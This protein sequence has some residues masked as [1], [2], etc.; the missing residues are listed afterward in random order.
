MATQERKRPWYLALALSVAL[1][2]GM[3]GAFGGY[4]SVMLYRAPNAI[5]ALPAAATHDIA[6][7]ADRAAVQLRFD[8]YVAALDASRARGWPLAVAT[9]LLGGAIVVFAT[10]TIAGSRS[11]R[12]ALLQLVFAQ[13]GLTV[14]SAWLM[15]DVDDAA[16]RFNNAYQS[17]VDHENA[18]ERRGADRTLFHVPS[19]W[20]P[21]VLALRT[22]SSAFVLVALTRRRARHFFDAASPA[23]EE[24]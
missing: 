8:A 18:R 6:D 11:G 5:L 3:M 21:V 4:A 2:L 15:R 20:T 10:R 19:A 12:A 16:Q 7:D 14:G 23:V 17:A 1:A 22:L 9:L 24:R 13:A